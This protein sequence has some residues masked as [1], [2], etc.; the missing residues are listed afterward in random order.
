MVRSNGNSRQRSRL[1]GKATHALHFC[2]HSSG[3]AR[4]TG[5]GSWRQRPCP[6]AG[7]NR[8]SLALI[9]SRSSANNS[10][11]KDEP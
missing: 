8:Q 3:I 7:E 11:N 2:P 9:F 10:S 4:Y 5:N 1:C 6:D